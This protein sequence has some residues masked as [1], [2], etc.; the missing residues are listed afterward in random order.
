MWNCFR[1]L[2]SAATSHVYSAS[3]SPCGVLLQTGVEQWKSC[4]LL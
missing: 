4:G 1:I 2:G 3:V